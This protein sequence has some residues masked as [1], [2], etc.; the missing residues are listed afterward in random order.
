MAYRSKL[1]GTNVK[2]LMFALRYVLI[3]KTFFS[4]LKQKSAKLP[5]H[6]LCISKQSTCKMHFVRCTSYNYKTE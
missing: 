2:G 5:T 6:F 4:I 3:R 1:T